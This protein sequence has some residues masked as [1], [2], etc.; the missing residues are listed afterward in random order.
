MNEL[1]KITYEPNDHNPVQTT[2]G[3]K[4]KNLGFKKFIAT[5]LVSAIVGAGAGVGGAELVLR[6]EDS[7]S[8]TSILTKEV[9]TTPTNLSVST[10]A[11]NG[12]VV[13]VAQAVMPAVVGVNTYASTSDLFG[14][15]GGL[16]QGYMMPRSNQK[17]DDYTQVSYGSGVIISQDGLIITNNHVISSGSKVSVTL[18]DGTQ[19]EAKILGQDESS[20]LAVLKIEATNLKAVS[21]GSSK[22]LQVGQSVVAI[23]NP[24]SEEFSQTVTNG[25]ISGVNRKL[26]ADNQSFSL[27]QTNAAIN[28]GN[29][30]GALV[31]SNGKL[32]GINTAKISAEGVEGIGFAIPIDEAMTIVQELVDKGSIEHAY[33]GFSGYLLTEELAKQAGVDYKGGV[34]V[35]SV[36]NNG[37]ADQA[38]IEPYDI[39]V[40][41][42][43][44]DV[45]S[46]EDITGLLAKKKP[47]DKITLT[48]IRNN[49]TVELDVTLGVKPTT[50]A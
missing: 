14:Q 16:M 42:D 47:K 4:S 31:D 48:V 39:I 5:V 36:V 15:Q 11:S 13:E 24:L 1:E 35:A 30:G 46:F 49:K 10:N 20:D 34:I 43:D 41:V 22:D 17:L 33:I 7:K 2:K 32:I 3:K 37:P 26:K 29:S 9:S 12:N 40:K 21:I 18:S 6:Q 50:S 28:S 44:V 19:Y 38:G 27:I 25:I 8:S 23:G 45:T